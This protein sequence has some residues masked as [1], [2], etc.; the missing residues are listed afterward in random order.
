MYRLRLYD[1]TEFA[2]RFCSARG[3]TLTAGIVTEADFFTVASKFCAQSASIMFI[4]D[5]TVETFT[6]YTKVLTINGATA[7]EYQ[8]ILAKE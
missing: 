5:D 7:G 4:Y 8:V 3:G 6:G 2:A 1:G